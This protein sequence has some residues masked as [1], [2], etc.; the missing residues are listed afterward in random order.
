MNNSNFSYFM[1][2]ELS[3]VDV[4]NSPKLSGMLALLLANNKVV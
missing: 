1:D 3:V 4:M 2:I